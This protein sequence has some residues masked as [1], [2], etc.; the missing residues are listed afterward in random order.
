MFAINPVKGGFTVK[1]VTVIARKNEL[2]KI[3]KCVEKFV[4]ITSLMEDA[5][6]VEIY[7]PEEEL[8][9]LIICL[10][11]SIDL[12][13]KESTIEVSTPDFVISSSLKR[14]ERSV[15][16][17]Y[18]KVPVEKL[19]DSAKPY[20]R[21][22]PSDVALTG[23]AG[24]IAMTGLFMNN[25][26]III[27]AMLLSPLL[28]PIYSFAIN[29]SAGREED[30]LKSAANLGILLGMVC[31]LSFILTALISQFMPLYLT[32]EIIARFDTNPVYIMMALLLGFASIFALSRGI[33]EG[34]AGVA[35]AAALLPPVVTAG[36]SFF[37]Y[38]ESAF[39]ALLLTVEN[40]VGL[41][42]GALI[43][44]HVL[45]IRPRRYHEKA[46]ARKYSMRMSLTLGLLL[47]LLFLAS[48]LL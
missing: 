9:D 41:M 39:R 3:E 16:K 10:Q 29:T 18:E 40:A 1:K 27:G 13:F 11:K 8:D 14:R 30:A 31:V 24:L 5:V 19:V 2:E 26:V 33:S 32:D 25:I 6:K 12:R 46:I 7:V 43:A 20:T 48:L 15:R 22:D 17:I 34:M 35:I 28:G 37:L 45:K 4:Y 42:A 47:L 36:I 23:V 44:T 38:P 21:I